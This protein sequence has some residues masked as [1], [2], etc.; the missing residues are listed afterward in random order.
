MKKM[1][2]VFLLI[3]AAGVLAAGSGLPAADASGAKPKIVKKVNPLYPEEAVKNRIEGVVLIEATSDEKGNVVSARVLPAKNPQPLLEEAALAA[4]R[5]WQYEPFLINGKA[6]GVTFTVTV[7]F[8]LDK[9]KKTVQD[10]PQIVKKVSPVY[11]EEA[12][13]KGIEGVV[14]IEATSDEKGN[15]VS[16]R[17]LPSKNPQPLLEEA[18]LAAVRQWKYEPFLKNGKAVG[19]T[20]TVTMNFAVNKDKKE[21]K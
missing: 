14:L 13:K 15:V 2:K 16:A 9:D 18:A 12:F 11:P 20:F 6:V 4:V 3:V 8:A 19:V 5:Q 17:V 1:K 21:E 10:H 7:T